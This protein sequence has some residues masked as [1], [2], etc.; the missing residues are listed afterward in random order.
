[1]LAVPLRHQM[2]HAAIPITASQPKV[3][4]D[5]G[6]KVD[7]LVNQEMYTLLACQVLVEL[8]R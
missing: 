8:Q 4:K 3:D 7:D 2:P 1:M 6:Q 5:N